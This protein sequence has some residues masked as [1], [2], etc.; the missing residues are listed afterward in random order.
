MERLIKILP[1]KV[2]TVI[3]KMNEN[4]ILR[5]TEIRLRVGKPIYFYMGKDEYGINDCGLSKRDGYFFS[6]DE[7][8]EMWRRLCDGAPYSTVAKQKAG[9]ITV[10]GN[11]IGFSGQY[12]SVDNNIKCIDK[13]Y[14]FCVRIMHERKGCANGI[15]K[16]LFVNNEPLNTLIISPPGCGKTTLIRDVA[17]LLSSDGFNVSIIDERDEIAAQNNG[18]PTLDVG[19]RTD[20]YSGISKTQAIDNMI[21]S[22]KPDVIVADELGG[23]DDL[24][25]IIKAKTRGVKVFSTIHGRTLEDIK[26]FKSF[27]DRYI[28]LSEKFGVGTVEGIYDQTLKECSKICC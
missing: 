18:I 9:Y 13:I 25:A 12:S 15:Y 14:S 10:E 6:Q 19:K 5:L 11:R 22:L 26:L 16:Y 4:E 17:R 20:V 24:E 27:F 23:N 3:E 2:S 7:S 8:F 1:R 28:F 21:R